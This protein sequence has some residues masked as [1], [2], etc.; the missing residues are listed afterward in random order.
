MNIRSYPCV[1]F[2]TRGNETSNINQCST[3]PTKH[4]LA[5]CI[6]EWK[7]VDRYLTASEFL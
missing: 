4:I 1:N 2:K 7:V 6:A 5:G 3:Q